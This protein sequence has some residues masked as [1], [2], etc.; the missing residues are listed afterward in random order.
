M[1][2]QKFV[3]TF[4]SP[5]TGFCGVLMLHDVGTGKTCTAVSVAEMYGL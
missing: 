1:Q 4:M 2:H 5:G 3:K